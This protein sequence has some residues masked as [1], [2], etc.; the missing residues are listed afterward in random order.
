MVVGGMINMHDYDPLIIDKV[1]TFLY[2]EVYYDN[3]KVWDYQ[4]INVVHK[5]NGYNKSWYMYIVPTR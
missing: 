3:N 1:E 4:F 5:I 2:W